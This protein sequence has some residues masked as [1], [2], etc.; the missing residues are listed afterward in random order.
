[1]SQND[2][3]DYF[4]DG[5]TDDLITD[6]SKF[7]ELFVISSNSVFAYKDQPIDVR[8]VARELGVRFVLEG[9][10]R[11]AGDDVRINAQLIDGGTGEHLWADRFDRDASDIFTVQDEVIRHIHQSHE[12]DQ[13]MQIEPQRVKEWLDQGEEFRFIDVRMPEEIQLA[14]LPEAEPLDFMDQGKYMNLPKDAKLVFT[15]KSGMRSLDVAA[16]FAG[17]GFTNVF[18][19]RGGLDGWRA[20]ID[21]SIPTY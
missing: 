3:S 18:S 12:T 1:M 14:K 21:A 4:A 5:F 11:R 13:R 16:Y 17:H 20:D 9:S 8:D 7:H 15:C 2:E 6:L 10:V 19:M